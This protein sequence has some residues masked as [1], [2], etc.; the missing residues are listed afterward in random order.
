MSDP[1]DGL[2]KFLVDLFDV[3]NQ[4]FVVRVPDL[5]IVLKKWSVINAESFDEKILV[6]RGE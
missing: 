6:P 1:R 5:A 4:E 2:G 3:L